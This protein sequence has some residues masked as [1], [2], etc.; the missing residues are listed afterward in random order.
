LLVARLDGETTDDAA[1]RALLESLIAA[2]DTLTR[3]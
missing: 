3:R 2:Q 1:E